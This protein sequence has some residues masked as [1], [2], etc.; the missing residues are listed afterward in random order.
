M[1]YNL[2]SS[3]SEYFDLVWMRK[4]KIGFSFFRFSI[5]DPPGPFG[6]P[7]VGL[8][9]ALSRTLCKAVRRE[10]RVYNLCVCVCGFNSTAV[11]A[12]KAQSAVAVSRQ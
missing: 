1:R 10:N 3:E 4:S 6:M 12:S 8:V 2:Y 5:I 7:E 9:L 11:Q